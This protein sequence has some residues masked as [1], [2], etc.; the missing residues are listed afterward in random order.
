MPARSTTK[1]RA[2]R[3]AGS[4][5]SGWLLLALDRAPRVGEIE[6]QVLRRARLADEHAALA[7]LLEPRQDVVLHLHIPGEV[8]FTCLQHGPGRGHGIAAAFH[9]DAVEERPI[10]HVVAGM[11]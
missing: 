4:E 5:R 2:A 1:A 11:Q 3:T 6:A 8:V 10:R 7:A 9:L